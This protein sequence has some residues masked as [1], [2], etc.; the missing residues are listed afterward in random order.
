MLTTTEQWYKPWGS[1]GSKGDNFYR[2]NKTQYSVYDLVFYSLYKLF[3]CLHNIAD[4]NFV[5]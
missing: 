5:S 3:E 2:S 4:M 1:I